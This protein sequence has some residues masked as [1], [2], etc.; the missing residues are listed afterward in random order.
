MVPGDLRYRYLLKVLVLIRPSYFFINIFG[1]DP[2]CVQVNVMLWF[3]QYRILATH[4]T[5]S[6]LVDTDV[7]TII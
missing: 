7:G 1:F 5:Y 3:F 2:P 4:G 6:T